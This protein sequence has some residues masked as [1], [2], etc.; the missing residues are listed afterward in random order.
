MEFRHPDLRNCYASMPRLMAAAG[1][2]PERHQDPIYQLM[3]MVDR[4]VLA[5]WDAGG[6]LPKH[7]EL[8]WTPKSA[9]L[10]ELID[11]IIAPEHREHLR[12]WYR[13][14]EAMNSAATAFRDWLALRIGE[15]LKPQFAAP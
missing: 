8:N 6:S 7:S 4:F 15:S 5:E 12:R 1:A 11:K 10:I 3:A 14:N 9:E 13:G 2:E